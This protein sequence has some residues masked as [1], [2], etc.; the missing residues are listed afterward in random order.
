MYRCIEVWSFIVFGTCE[1]GN[2]AMEISFAA[3]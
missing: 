3:L 1:R 2:E